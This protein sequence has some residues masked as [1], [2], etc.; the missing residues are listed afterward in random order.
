MGASNFSRLRW[1]LAGVLLVLGCNAEPGHDSGEVVD[2]PQETR[3]ATVP[4]PV[5]PQPEATAQ[6]NATPA[7]SSSPPAAVSLETPELSLEQLFDIRKAEPSP[8]GLDLEALAKEGADVD[9]THVPGAVDTLRERTRVRHESGK[10][11]PEGARDQRVGVAEAGVAVP[12][13]KDESV[14]LR[15]GVRVDY[16][17][18]DGVLV[19]DPDP[20]P[21]VGVEVRF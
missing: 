4:A 3:T 19:D 11:G 6:A 20:T 17:T 10:V 12:V 8:P 13:N 7:T 18:D 15:S 14:H 2:A 9:T 1:R 16:E 21:T 5:T